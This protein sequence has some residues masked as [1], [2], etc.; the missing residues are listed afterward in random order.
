[1]ENFK[2]Q[3]DITRRWTKLTKEC[4]NIKSNCIICDFVP[5]RLKSLCKVKYYVTALYKKFGKP[6]M[7]G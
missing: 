3:K 2:P 1:M 7:E 5:T 4:Y 6:K